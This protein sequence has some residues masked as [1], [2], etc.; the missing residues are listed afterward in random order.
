MCGSNITW[1]IVGQKKRES[2]IKPE[3]VPKRGL[4]A[5]WARVLR[6]TCTRWESIP[7]GLSEELKDALQ[8]WLDP[9]HWSLTLAKVSSLSVVFE[10][11]DGNREQRCFSKLRASQIF[12]D[13][14]PILKCE[15]PPMNHDIDAIVPDLDFY[16]WVSILLQNGF[17]FGTVWFQGNSFSTSCW[18]SIFL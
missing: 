14:E 15:T 10:F 12:R 1:R 3:V 9:F 18:S 13:W 17:Q 16:A 4:T 8:L 6:S 11:S 7:P 2:R 5:F